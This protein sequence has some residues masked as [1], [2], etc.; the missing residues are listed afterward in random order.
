MTQFTG[1][2]CSVSDAGSVEVQLAAGSV[3]LAEAQVA[4]SPVLSS[5]AD[6]PGT[7]VIP[8]SERAFKCWHLYA[9]TL[10]R[11]TIQDV[12][13]VLQVQSPPTCRACCTTV[14]PA[15]LVHD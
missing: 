4:R 10:E 9:I 13:L 12:K 6:K 2:Q 7:G 1:L 5:I 14:L 11:Q 15:R 3:Q 8:M